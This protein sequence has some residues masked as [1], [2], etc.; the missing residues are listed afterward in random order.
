MSLEVQISWQ[1]RHFVNLDAQISR[2][3]QHLVNLESKC[4]FRGRRTLCLE[5]QFAAGA[6]LGEAGSADFVAGAHF[7]S[8]CNSR[9]AQHLVKLE[10]QISW[11]AQHF[12]NLA[13][14]ISWQVQHFL[15]LVAQIS[16]QAQQF[17]TCEPR[18][19]DFVAGAAL[20]AARR[21]RSQDLLS[22]ACALIC[23]LSGPWPLD[24][25]TL[26]FRL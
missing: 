21:S 11:Q 5:V 17:V 23:V 12:A 1:A 20:C 24:L 4:R 6:A 10:V 2:Q 18:S 22:D 15:N 16:W 19:E 14:Q 25:Q 26:A 3:V 9:Q 8:K 13:A 7:A